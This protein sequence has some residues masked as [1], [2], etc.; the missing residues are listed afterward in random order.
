MYRALSATTETLVGL[1]KEHVQFLSAA[2]GGTWEVTAQTPREMS[3]KNQQGLSVWLYR[4][5]RDEHHLNQAPRRVAFN[6]IEPKPLPLRLHYLITPIALAGEEGLLEQQI[7]GVV[8]Q[9]FHDQPILQGASLQPELR[10]TTDRITVRLESQ[11]LEEIT[12]VW[13]ALERSY[14][15]CVSYEVSVVMVA[16]NNEADELAPVDVVVPEYGI[17]TGAEVSP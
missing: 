12:R 7:L 6:Q 11:G 3:E 4:V 5:E 10:S 17:V 9:T 16:S 2:F 8:L 15:L 1:L 14:Q 13:D